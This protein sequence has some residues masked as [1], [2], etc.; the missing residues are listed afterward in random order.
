VDPWLLFDEIPFALNNR[1]K[2]IIIEPDGNQKADYIC[3]DNLKQLVLKTKL[4]IAIIAAGLVSGMP[5]QRVRRP[6]YN[7]G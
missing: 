4:R 3:R 1:T 7:K 2:Q 5:A 6:N